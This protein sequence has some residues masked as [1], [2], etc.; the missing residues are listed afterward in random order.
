[1]V[2]KDEHRSMNAAHDREV[3]R[4]KIGEDREQNEQCSD[5]QSRAYEQPTE[6]A[7]MGPV[8]AGERRWGFADGPASQRA[9]W[10][11]ARGGL[12]RARDPGRKGEQERNAL[13]VLSKVALGDARGAALA[14]VAPAAFAAHARRLRV[15]F[16]RTRGSSSP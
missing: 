1:D 7:R 11:P 13:S 5:E 14:R 10:L 2:R 6:R 9:W 3:A 8:D 12:R 15:C 4:E 16:S